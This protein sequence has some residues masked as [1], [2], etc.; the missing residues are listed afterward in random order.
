[1]LP[2]GPDNQEF[3]SWKEI[4]G[5]LG[6]GIRTAQMWEKGRGLPVHRLPGGN[7]VIAYSA[8][9]DE[10]KLSAPP[11]STVATDVDP[12]AVKQPVR[13][14]RLLLTAGILSLVAGAVAIWNLH[15]APEPHSYRVQGRR[16]TMLDAWER[17]L[18]SLGYDDDLQEFDATGVQHTKVAIEDLDGDGIAE[19]VVAASGVRGLREEVFCYSATGAPLWSYRV[20]SSVKTK[21]NEFFPPFQIRSFVVLPPDISG[22]RRVAISASHYR[23]FPSQV[24]ILNNRGKPLREYWHGG[25]LATLQVAGRKLLAGGVRNQTNEATLLVL[26]PDTAGGASKEDEKHQILGKGPAAGV[27]RYLLP[28]SCLNQKFSTMNSV[29]LIDVTKNEIIAHTMERETPGATLMW[30]F[31]TALTFRHTSES[32]LYSKYKG[33]SGLSASCLAS[34][35]LKPRV[36][37]N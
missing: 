36:N 24:A 10:W 13:W 20:L 32:S 21:D 2:A 1:M 6:V 31:D 5:Y 18:W 28:R 35:V 33:E 25:H 4:A 29:F 7:R 27:V 22:K 11:A 9:L 19:V 30:S 15:K 3:S 26:D 34:E 16:I 17:P 8:E 23:L 37:D 14:T 12:T